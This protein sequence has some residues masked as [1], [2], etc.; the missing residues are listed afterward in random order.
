MMPYGISKE[1][2]E[3]IKKSDGD[4]VFRL[5]QHFGQGAASLTPY[6]NWHVVSIYYIPADGSIVMGIERDRYTGLK[7]MEPLRYIQLGN[8]KTD[9]AVFFE[10]TKASLDYD[11][12]YK[13]FMDV[14]EEVMKIGL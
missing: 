6:L 10:S 3:A 2:I 11:V 14:C 8:K 5:S 13:R 1:D 4:G 9:V 12:L 7:D